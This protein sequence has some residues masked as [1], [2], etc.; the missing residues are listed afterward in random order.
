[1]GSGGGGDK[2][3]KTNFMR[4]L[5]I[6]PMTYIISILYQVYQVYYEITRTKS[7]QSNDMTDII[8]I[9]TWFWLLQVFAGQNLY[10]VTTILKF[11]LICTPALV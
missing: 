2:F 3:I 4:K 1:M 7:D 11:K 8:S 9:F 10:A 6:S 5:C